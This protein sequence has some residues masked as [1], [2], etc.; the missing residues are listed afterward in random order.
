MTVLVEMQGLN[1]LIH[2]WSKCKL[3]CNFW[4]AVVSINQSPQNILTN[5]TKIPI[6][7]CK[8]NEGAFTI[9]FFNNCKKFSEQITCPMIRG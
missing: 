5:P 1:S 9:V 3:D 6:S 4:A 8:I 7:V 2:D